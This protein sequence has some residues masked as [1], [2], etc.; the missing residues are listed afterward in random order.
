MYPFLPFP[1]IFFY[2]PTKTGF[3]IL[4]V[5]L[6]FRKPDLSFRY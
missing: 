2:R 4:D 6:Y 5:V 3:Y 1:Y